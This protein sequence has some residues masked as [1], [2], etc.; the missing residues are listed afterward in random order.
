MTQYTHP[1]LADFL[2]PAPFKLGAGDAQISYA[3]GFWDKASEQEIAA[4]GFIEYVAPAPEP[5]EPSTDPAD[6]PL[7]PW[8][9]KALVMYLGKDGDI[10]AAINAI[11]DDLGRATAMSRYE[12]ASAYVYG[13]PLMQ[14]LRAAVGLSEQELSDAWM[15]AKDL[16]S[17]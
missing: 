14:Q 9:F 15:V 5:V 2:S 6:Y 13:D 3:R 10:R 1:D 11:T 7:L 17:S 12:N 8:Q 16:A 4:L